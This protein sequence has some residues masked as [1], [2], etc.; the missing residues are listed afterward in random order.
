ML[1]D[2]LRAILKKVNAQQDAQR[3]EMNYHVPFIAHGTHVAPEVFKTK[4][5][6][7]VLAKFPDA[8]MVFP[9]FAKET[10]NELNAIKMFGA[11]HPEIFENK[12]LQRDLEIPERIFGIPTKMDD[13]GQPIFNE[14]NLPEPQ[15][16]TFAYALKKCSAAICFTEERGEPVLIGFEDK[17]KAFEKGEQIG[18][19]Y[20][21]TGDTFKPEYSQNG[22]IYEFTSQEYVPVV[23]HRE[24]SPMEAM[25][26][27]AQ[28]VMFRDE[29]AFVDWVENGQ[30]AFSGVMTSETVQTLAQEVV[31][32]KATYI[33]ATDRGVNPLIHDLE[34]AQK[35]FKKERLV[36]NEMNLV[37]NVLSQKNDVSQN[38]GSQKSE[39]RNRI[40]VSLVKQKSLLR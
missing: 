37:R 2:E 9:K 28:F 22:Q 12:N 10:Q 24:V 14:Q 7:D 33:N 18:H 13:N 23:Y 20:V 38:N 35:N 29:R 16:G 27:N 11:Q 3:A 40:D 17:Y 6:K 30:G 19:I 39:T 15:D 26:H 25:K 1:Y 21:L 5:P 36:K 34:T 8:E 31:E 32:G 4:V